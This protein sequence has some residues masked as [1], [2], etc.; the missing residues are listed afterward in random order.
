M[1]KILIFCLI[2]LS[3]FIIY[4]CNMDKKVY[5]LTLGDPLGGT[6]NYGY[7]VKEYLKE[8]KVLEKYVKEFSASNMRTYDVINSIKNNKSVMIYGREQ[9]LQNALIKADLV[10]M[11]I[12]ID[13]VFNK[14]DG[15]VFDYASV[16]DYIDSLTDDLN[17]LLKLMREYCKE[18]IILIGY[19]SSSDVNDKIISYLNKKYKE[20]CDDYKVSYIDLDDI[21]RENPSFL[22]SS[23][24]LTDD[25]T[26]TIAREVIGIINKK[27][28]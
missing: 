19:Y 11:Y 14:I 17:D 28:F 15:E 9:T 18:D 20:V 13:D 7:Y 2:V 8:K 12:S 16:Y 3:V 1:K 5:Y 25:G 6:R 26:M 21:F 27:V 4:L 24:K 10:T 23:F 22:E